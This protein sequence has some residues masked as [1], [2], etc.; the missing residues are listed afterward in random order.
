MTGD[1]ASVTGSVNTLWQFMA[2]SVIFPLKDAIARLPPAENHC[3]STRQSSLGSKLLGISTVS[4]PPCALSRRLTACS[5]PATMCSYDYYI[6][7]CH[8]DVVVVDMEFCGNQPVDAYG[9]GD[10]TAGTSCSRVEATCHGI[11]SLLGL[12]C[13]EVANL[14]NGEDDG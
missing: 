12:E 10:A 9:P 3:K 11:C 13:S 5:D 2:I 7:C 6:T 14:E 1:I 8:H 4:R